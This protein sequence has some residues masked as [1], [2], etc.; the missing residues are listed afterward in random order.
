VEEH[1]VRPIGHAAWY[2]TSKIAAE[3]YL[4]QLRCSADLSPVI[5]R[6]ASC[7]GPGMKSASVV[8]HFAEMACA[9][10][11]ILRTKTD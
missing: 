5:L 2:L 10:P 1:P 8:A 11:C 4:E 7:Y 3:F 6:I 9:L